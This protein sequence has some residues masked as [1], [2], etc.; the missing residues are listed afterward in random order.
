MFLE[1]AAAAEADDLVTGNLRH[2][3][4]SWGRTRVVNAREELDLIA[5]AAR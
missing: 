4:E 1:C 5:G 2:S 3:P